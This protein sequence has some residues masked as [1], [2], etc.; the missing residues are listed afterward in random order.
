M[1]P[2]EDDSRARAPVSETGLL[3]LAEAER[4]ATAGDGVLLTWRSVFSAHRNRHARRLICG[5]GPHARGW[6]IGRGEDE[7]A[8]LPRGGSMLLAWRFAFFAPMGQLYDMRG[9]APMP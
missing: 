9:R 2:E 7:A 1:A 8:H 5:P 3:L 6:T 4:C